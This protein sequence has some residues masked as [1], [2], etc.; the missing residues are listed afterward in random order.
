MPGFAFP[1][2]GPLGLGS[3]PYRTVIHRPVPR[4]YAP[5]RL[6]PDLLESLRLSLALRY[7]SRSRSLCVPL[8]A[9]LWAESYPVRARALVHAVPLLFR[10]LPVRRQMALPSSRVAPVNACPALRPRWC[11]GPM[12]LA[13]PG[14]LPSA[15]CKA[16]AFTSPLRERLILPTTTIH[17]SGLGDAACILAPSGF[18]HP[19]TGMHADFASGLPAQL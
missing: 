14:L 8:P 11:P 19:I 9:R 6:P 7:L 5:L 17:I 4:Y 15:R 16:S 12:T 1:A 2:V 10:S 13:V 18:E 3:P